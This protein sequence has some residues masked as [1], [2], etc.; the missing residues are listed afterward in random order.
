MD[1]NDIRLGRRLR[2]LRPPRETPARERR[3]EDAE[4]GA[5]WSPTMGLW[6]AWIFDGHH[7]TILPEGRTTRARA[8]DD[9]RRHFD[10]IF[11]EEKPVQKYQH[12]A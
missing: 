9:G 5:Q 11:H 6:L 10:R 7:L 4:W 12:T 1:I 2:N 8:L 3:P